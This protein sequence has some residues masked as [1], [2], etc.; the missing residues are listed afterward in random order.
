MQTITDLFLLTVI[1]VSLVDI[2]GV[3]QSIER[4]VAKWLGVGKVSIPMIG[5]SYCMSHHAML[6]YLL[7]T[8]TF[9]LWHYCL[10]L[11]LAMMTPVIGD[12][13]ITVR[14]ALTGAVARIQTF[15]DI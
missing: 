3:I 11:L 8:N 1:I 4:G 7:V 2:S 5:C 9:S 12:V 10:V 14:E 13:L 6:L 15:L